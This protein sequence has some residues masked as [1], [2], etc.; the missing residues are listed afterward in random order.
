MAQ[1][2]DGK[3]QATKA[4]QANI[5]MTAEQDWSLKRYCNPAGMTTQKAIINA[6]RGAERF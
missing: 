1:A 2:E 6:L 5:R 3:P 4:M